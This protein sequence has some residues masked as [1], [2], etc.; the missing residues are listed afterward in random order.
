[1]SKTNMIGAK[2]VL[3]PL[4]TTTSLKLVDGTSST[5]S[6]EFRSVIGA[7]QYLSL[8]RPDISFSVNKLSQF[9]HK[10]TVI[11]WTAAKRLLRYLKHTIFHV[12]HIRKKKNPALNSLHILMRIGRATMMIGPPP[13]HISHFLVS[14]LSPGVQRN[15]GQWHVHPLKQNIEPLPMQPPRHH[16][17]SHYS[18]N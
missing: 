12:L 11:H 2:D 13:P 7:L 17:F 1:M 8:T 16:G 9:M 5:N 10:P 4:S 15:K 14:I 6:T 18:R 3:T